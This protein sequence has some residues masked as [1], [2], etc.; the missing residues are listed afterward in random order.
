MLNK[1]KNFLS[2]VGKRVWHA[3]KS[4]VVGIGGGVVASMG[5]APVSI[6]IGVVTPL[7]LVSNEGLGA[8]PMGL[9]AGVL[10][11]LSTLAV[12]QVIAVMSPLVGVYDAVAW[13]ALGEGSGVDKIG[14]VINDISVV[15]EKNTDDLVRRRT[16]EV[17]E[18]PAVNA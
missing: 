5:A 8:L 15:M 6:G 14:D 4:L 18:A 12:F 11:M 9:M 1:I 3:C 13:L 7:L 2:E 10:S 16:V 17:V